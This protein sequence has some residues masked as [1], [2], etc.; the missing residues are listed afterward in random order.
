MKD[1]ANIEFLIDLLG[2]VE[3]AWLDRHDRMFVYKLSDKYPE[4]RDELLEFFED[5]VLGSEKQTDRGLLEVEERVHQWLHSTGLDLAKKAASQAWAARV[6]SDQATP[7]STISADT[8]NPSEQ[9]GTGGGKTETWLSFLR[10]RIGEKVPELA[11]SLPNVTTEYLVLVSRH[12]NVVPERVKRA[13]AQYVE[14]RWSIPAEESFLYLTSEPRTLRAASRSQ[15]F[16]AE[17]SSF[18]ELLERA[19]LDAEQKAFWLK[20]TK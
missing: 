14:E 16:E 17:P 15:P 13:F 7:A 19:M 2:Q 6:T 1:T 12:P 20:L 8:R 5:L 11:K 18:Q 9:K 4:F 3:R 10:R